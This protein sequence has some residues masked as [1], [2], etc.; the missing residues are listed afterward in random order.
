MKYIPITQ[1]IFRELVGAKEL[2]CGHLSQDLGM[3]G[4]EKTKSYDY[5]LHPYTKVPFAILGSLLSYI[6]PASDKDPLVDIIGTKEEIE[7]DPSSWILDRMGDL[8]N[9]FILNSYRCFGISSPLEY[10]IIP[11]YG[12]GIYELTLP[13]I[14]FTKKMW[15]KF[16]KYYDWSKWEAEI[17]YKNMFDCF[18][19]T[20]YNMNLKQHYLNLVGAKLYELNN[21]EGC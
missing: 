21:E 7:P 15:V 4:V 1:E 20:Y 14:G 8:D 6:F 13:H 5:F 18:S 3:V 9:T 10:D 12:D 19:G 11:K 17:A 2:T 16:E